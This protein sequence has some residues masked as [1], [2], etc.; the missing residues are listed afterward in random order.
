MLQYKVLISS[1]AVTIDRLSNFIGIHIL[2]LLMSNSSITKI[3]SL[4]KAIWEEGHRAVFNDS[5]E[6]ILALSGYCIAIK[7][8]PENGEFIT[9][10]RLLVTLRAKPAC[11]ALV[12]CSSNTDVVA[13][14]AACVN[15]VEEEEQPLRFC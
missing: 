14:R 7:L 8:P 13:K 4:L 1:I 11:M 15:V 5:G 2:Y 12:Q 10:H 3:T 6:F 9:W